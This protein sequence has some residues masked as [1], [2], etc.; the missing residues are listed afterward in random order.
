MAQI[1]IEKSLLEQIFDEMLTSLEG[2][3]EF[4]A[5]SVEVIK[6]LTDSGNLKTQKVI[7]G[8]KSVVGGSDE[9]P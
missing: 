6:R 3:K 8:L 7:E 4:D 9:A 5:C 1:E 2:Q